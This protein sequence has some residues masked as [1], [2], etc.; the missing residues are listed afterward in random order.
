MG[1]GDAC[2]QR[3]LPS[4]PGGLRTLEKVWLLSLAMNS[5]PMKFPRTKQGNYP[6]TTWD[7][8][9]ASVTKLTY[10]NQLFCP[11]SSNFAPVALVHLHVHDLP[12]QCQYG[13]QFYT[14]QLSMTDCCKSHHQQSQ[15]TY[16]W[17]LPSF[18]SAMDFH[19]LLCEYAH[20]CMCSCQ[21]AC[22]RWFLHQHEWLHRTSLF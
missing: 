18:L 6:C 13:Q 9:R 8:G 17:H 20:T 15:L 19:W 1:A 7:P 4:I 10:V 2:N 21:H 11:G 5:S 12:F 14:Q 22:Q 3:T 16:G